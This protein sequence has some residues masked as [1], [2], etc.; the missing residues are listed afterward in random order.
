MMNRKLRSEVRSFLFSA[1]SSSSDLLGQR[2]S[3]QRVKVEKI[4]KKVTSSLFPVAGLKSEAASNWNEEE[5]LKS[6]IQ[7]YFLCE[8]IYHY[9]GLEDIQD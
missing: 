7:F 9:V 8:T 6:S 3:C 4:E 1:S 5:K 2:K